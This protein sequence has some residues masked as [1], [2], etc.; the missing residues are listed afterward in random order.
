MLLTLM[1]GVPI[2]ANATLQEDIEQVRRTKGVIESATLVINGFA[3]RVDAAIAQAMANG[4][5]AE[6]LAPLSQVVDET[7]AAA[8][9]LAAAVAANPGPVTPA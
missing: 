2:M 6:E 1:E 7:E 8:G 4:A 9:T 5:T 3:A